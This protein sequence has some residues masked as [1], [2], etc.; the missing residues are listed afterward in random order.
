MVGALITD[1]TAALRTL[2][3]YNALSPV[4]CQLIVDQATPATD[5]LRAVL[6]I[7]NPPLPLE[8]HPLATSRT[9]FAP[10]DQRVEEAARAPVQEPTIVDDTV[11][12]P[13]VPPLSAPIALPV[14]PSADVV[15]SMG[16]TVS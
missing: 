9:V 11:V 10:P 2:S 8:S 5:A 16:P 12:V 15:P 4:T 1:L 3:V 13:S 6:H 7:Y 14:V